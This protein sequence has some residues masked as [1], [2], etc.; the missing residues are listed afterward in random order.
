MSFNPLLS[1]A[2]NAKRQKMDM[3]CDPQWV[4]DLATE[5]DQLR[6]ELDAIKG[7]EPVTEVSAETFSSDGTSD[8]ITANLPIGTKLYALPPQ[9]PDA[10]SVPELLD[11][12]Q[13]IYNEVEGN[14]EPTVRDL[15]NQCGRNTPTDP[16][17]IYEYC[18][19]IKAVIVEAT[20]QAEE[21]E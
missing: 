10:V 11:A 14:I 17:E 12:L 5:R 9:Q 7:Q 6:A 2:R 20:R 1:L 15:V 19:R 4:L 21:G 16:N 18:A 13:N 8:I 3:Q